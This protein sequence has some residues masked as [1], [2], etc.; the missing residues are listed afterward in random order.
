MD[1]VNLIDKNF[2]TRK[3]VDDILYE[4]GNGN[5]IAIHGKAGYGKV[6]ACMMY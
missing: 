6:D 5:S 2:I 3:E 1:S 4:I